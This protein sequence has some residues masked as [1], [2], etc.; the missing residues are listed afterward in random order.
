MLTI[1]IIAA[2]VCFILAAIGVAA[3][4]VNLVALG[5]ALWALAVAIEKAVL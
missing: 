4:K 1:L 5:L 2:V 3:S